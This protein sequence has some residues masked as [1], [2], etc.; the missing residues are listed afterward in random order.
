MKTLIKEEKGKKNV[1]TNL[2]LINL[3]TISLLEFKDLRRMI[4][5]VEKYKLLEDKEE[6]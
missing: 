2:E 3:K 1:L 5:Q 6:Y 4:T